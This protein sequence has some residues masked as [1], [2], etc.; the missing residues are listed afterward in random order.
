MEATVLLAN[1][2]QGDSSGT[3]HALGLGWTQTTTPLGQCAVVVFLEL[4]PHEQLT[5]RDLH[6]ELVDED[7]T[8][9]LFGT[10]PTTDQPAPLTIAGKIEAAAQAGHTPC[11]ST[12]NALAFNIAAGMALKD[13]T[14]YEWRLEIDQTLIARRSF[15]VA[16]S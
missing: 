5:S 16:N 11:T 1:S 2:A 10:D 4:E 12:T 15:A 9:V 7:G 14:R 3:V 6:L 8:Q 13:N